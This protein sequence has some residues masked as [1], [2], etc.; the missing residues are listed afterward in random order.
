MG[1]GGP[2]GEALASVTLHVLQG[3]AAMLEGDPKAAA[4]SYFKGMQRQAAAQ[5]SSDPPLFW[6]SVR[7]SYAAAL[8][9]NGEH[10]RA[11]EH[12]L[13]SLSHWPNDPLALF[14]LS[15]VVRT[16]GDSA[17][18]DRILKRAQSVWA[19]NLATVPLSHI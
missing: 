5:F 15:K 7:R 17:G 19:G 8:L 18:A 10:D 3:R 6:Y 9:A 2:R 13:A 14:A 12:L 1:L 4:D 11:R 16:G